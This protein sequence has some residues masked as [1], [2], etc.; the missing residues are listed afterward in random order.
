M[1]YEK[2]LDEIFK[3][4]DL[5]RFGVGGGGIVGEMISPA[6]DRYDLRGTRSSQL[7]RGEGLNSLVEELKLMKRSL[8]PGAERRVNRKN[9]IVDYSEREKELR[10]K[11]GPSSTGRIQQLD[12]NKQL[13]KA[14]G[15]LGKHRRLL[16]LLL[17]AAL[18]GGGG[19][20]HE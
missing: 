12:P 4:V 2:T 14:F 18:A 7:A 16:P 3:Q 1:P 6:L 13:K 9:V 8:Q 10:K 17:L 11:K 19:M 15:K 5:D 20:S